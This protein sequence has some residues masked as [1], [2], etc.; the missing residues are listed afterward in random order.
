MLFKIW[1]LGLFEEIKTI[2]NFPAVIKEFIDLFNIVS[3]E[4]V[5]IILE[6]L[7]YILKVKIEYHRIINNIYF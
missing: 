1:K 2:I 6:G 3:E 5:H 4:T 7:Q